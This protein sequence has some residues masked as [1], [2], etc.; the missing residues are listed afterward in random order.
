MPL[1]SLVPALGSR[2]R[3]R[4]VAFAT[5]EAR[6][7]CTLLAY[8]GEGHEE[9]WPVPTDLPPQASDAS[10]YALRSWIEQSFEDGKRGGWQWQKTRM[11]YPERAARF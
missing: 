11:A 5:A 8:W 3:G 7:D 4:G 10:W 6:L 1:A 9:A 2:R